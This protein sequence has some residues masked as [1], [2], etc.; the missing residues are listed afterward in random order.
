MI[1]WKAIPND[2]N[3]RS[4]F[5]WSKEKC[6]F[7]LVSFVELNREIYTLKG[8]L[9]QYVEWNQMRGNG[10]NNCYFIKLF[11]LDKKRNYIIYDYLFSI[12]FIYI[13]KK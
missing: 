13:N 1:F 2:A 12:Y 5:F 10:N 6:S 4:Y 8:H 9:I 3:I 11:D 7:I